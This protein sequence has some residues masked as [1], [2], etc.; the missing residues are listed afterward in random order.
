ME[1]KRDADAAGLTWPRSNTRTTQSTSLSSDASS[2]AVPLNPPPQGNPMAPA[3]LGSSSTGDN[4]LT[5]SGMYSTG[6]HPP[7]LFPTSEHRHPPPPHQGRF[8]ERLVHQIHFK[9]F[10]HSN[11]TQELFVMEIPATGIS[12]TSCPCHRVAGAFVSIFDI[13]GTFGPTEHGAANDL[14]CG[15]PNPRDVTEHVPRGYRLM[16][17]STF[18]SVACSAFCTVDLQLPPLPKKETLPPQGVCVTHLYRCKT[19]VSCHYIYMQG[20]WQLF[21]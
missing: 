17:N 4:S 10:T 18:F 9:I 20:A 3:T 6:T 2:S 15:S 16:V 19:S 1:H 11:N 14:F 5:N 21:P 12:R 7:T 13:W 8:S